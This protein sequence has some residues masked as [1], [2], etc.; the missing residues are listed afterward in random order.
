[1]YVRVWYPLACCTHYILYIGTLCIIEDSYVEH[2]VHLWESS[3]WIPLKYPS[4]TS[5]A[6]TAKM[7]IHSPMLI[8][9]AKNMVCKSTFEGIHLWPQMFTSTSSLHLWRQDWLCC[10]LSVAHVLRNGICLSLKRAELQTHWLEQVYAEND[11]SRAPQ[12]MGERKMGLSMKSQLKGLCSHHWLKL[13]FRR[14]S[15]SK[16]SWACSWL[17]IFTCISFSQ[18]RQRM[19]DV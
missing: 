1:M 7:D 9:V 3:F 19:G 18:K 16:P 4:H 15:C 11:N 14:C 2:T 6:K 17:L 12:Q 8:L 10:P 13:T 5:P